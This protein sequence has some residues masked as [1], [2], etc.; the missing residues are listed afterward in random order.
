MHDL[1]AAFGTHLRGTKENGKFKR[2]ELAPILSLNPA[3]PAIIVQARFSHPNLRGTFLGN[4]GLTPQPIAMI[5]AFGAFEPDIVLVRMA[6]DDEVEIL[7]T[8]DTI[9]ISRGNQRKALLVSDIKHAGEANSSY[10]SEVVLY[11]VLLANWLRLNHFENSFFVADRL[12]LW[13]RAKEISG[14]AELVATTPGAGIT[15]KLE[16]FLGDL[17]K[18][19]F[20]IFF[21]T[22][23][24]FFNQDLHW[25]GTSIRDARRATSWGTGTGFEP[26][27]V[28]FSTLTART[29]V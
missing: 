6:A 13:T 3:S 15:E 18:V 9:P 27:S 24:H 11:A 28:R 14:L 12:G 25:I 7:L 4:I 21:Q 20:Q 17:E 29:I 8:G 10:S 23:S 26:R 16:A 2:I 19:D 5:P 22:V 1:E